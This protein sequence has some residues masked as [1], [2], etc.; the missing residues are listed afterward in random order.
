MVTLI[1]GPMYG[2][3]SSALVQKMERYIYA[4]KHI[5]FIRPKR[6]NRGY[7]THSGLVDIQKI[8]KDGDGLF[9][10]EEFDEINTINFLK[11]DAVFVD[12]YFMIKNCKML[13]A[14]MP[15]RTHCDI[16]FAGLLATSEN[17]LFDEAK[18]ILPYCDEILKL[19]AVCMS[20]G[21][22]H[23]NYSAYFGGDKKDTILVG[24]NLYKALCRR[25]YKEIIGKL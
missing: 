19:N 22:Q 10:I 11:Y 15:M 20:C 7:V 9:E 4:K 24:D 2:G 23:G 17:E 14:T 6:D 8:L 21:S 25:C 13:C 12:E 16:Y 18:S 5:C 3:K 1:C